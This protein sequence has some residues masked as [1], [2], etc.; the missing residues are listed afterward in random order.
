M[1]IKLFDPNNNPYGE[2]SNVSNHS[3]EIDG[4]TWKTVSH[5]VYAMMLSTPAYRDRV[6]NAETKTIFDEY[7]HFLSKIEIDVVSKALTDSLKEKFATD[8]LVSLLIG[9]K[10]TPLIYVSDDKILGVGVDRTGLNLLG[11]YMMQLR[12]Q[13][14]NTSIANIKDKTAKTKLIAIYDTYRAFTALKMAYSEGDNLAGYKNKTVDEIITKFGSANI[15]QLDKEAIIQLYDE[16]SLSPSIRLAVDGKVESLIYAVM[17]E[18]IRK[19]DEKQSLKRRKVV[20]EMYA[21]YIL[22]REYSEIKE[23]D[24]MKAK[25]EQFQNLGALERKKLE[26]RVYQLYKASM[27]SN[28]L[29]DSIDK[30][31]VTIESPSEEDFM[32]ADATLISDVKSD[33]TYVEKF[34][35]EPSGPPIEFGARMPENHKYIKFSP[36]YPTMF[37]ID[38]LLY[39]SITHYIFASLFATLPDPEGRLVAIANSQP[40]LNWD[41]KKI[42]VLKSINNSYH[43]L[44]VDKRKQPINE[45]SFLTPDKLMG[46]YSII[47]KEQND[48]MLRYNAVKA[49]DTKFSNKNRNLQILLLKTGKDK[50]EWSDK[51]DDVLGTGESN[52]ENF[53]GEYM[54]KI[55]RELYNIQSYKEFP[56]NREA[57]IN[58]IMYR[59]NTNRD[60]EINQ[61]MIDDNITIDK[62]EEMIPRVSRNSIND[63]EIINKFNIL[64]T[65]NITMV[66][67]DDSWDSWIKLKMTDICNV[68]TVMKSNIDN[69]KNKHEITVDFVTSILDNIYYPCSQLIEMSNQ[70]N[71]PIPLKFSRNFRQCEGY[72]NVSDEV[73]DVVWKRIAVIIYTLVKYS[74]QSTIVSSIALLTKIEH[75]SSSNKTCV[76]IIP[77]ED[78]NCI[79]TAIINI[80]K[81]IVKFKT[82]FSDSTIIVP[83]DVKVATSIILC[84]DVVNRPIIKR[85][86]TRSE[87]IDESTPDLMWELQNDDNESIINKTWGEAIQKQKTDNRQGKKIFSIDEKDLSAIQIALKQDMSAYLDDVN[88]V[89][90]EILEMTY[91]INTYKISKQIKRNRV[92][93]FSSFN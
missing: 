33:D 23:P 7:T 91:F 83:D 1:V 82:Q 31:M 50:I 40:S 20:F 10:N 22:S 4:E 15:P 17:K 84:R 36:V 8:E 5:Y 54:N 47:A 37:I 90:I 29:T 12:M 78:D 57:Q 34:Y 49:L 14:E 67:E 26:E 61:M 24:Y 38:N 43:H 55:R 72:S 80:M 42:S 16:G 70:I 53:V 39:P 21:D 51:N 18:G 25:E 46:E 19:F 79:V 58:S 66:L 52:G 69:D 86:T 63:N 45:T 74:P 48:N 60:K 85:K 2:L 30:I 68:L 13:L 56:E 81:G 3:M 89:A 9:T 76:S 73:I 28:S 11:I 41:R 77:R 59:K 75:I 62:A 88:N 87:E 64:T 65:E 35:T 92:N 6:R 71:I 27:L 44:L 93:Y 32:I